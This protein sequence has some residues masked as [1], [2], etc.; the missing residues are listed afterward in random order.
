M[1]GLAD[2]IVV[3][4]AM[5]GVFYAAVLAF[6]QTNLRRLLSFAVVSHTS[7]IVIG[8][9]YPASGMGSWR[10]ICSSVNFGLAVTV[11]LFI[12][13]FVFRRTASTDLG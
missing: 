2:L 4:F 1:T 10:R 7:L 13:G 12:V 5:A 3:G 9:F 6:L 11:M 8:L